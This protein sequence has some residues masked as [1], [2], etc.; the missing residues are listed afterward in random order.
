MSIWDFTCADTLCDL[1]VRKSLKRACSAAEEREFKKVDKYLNM[2]DNYHFVP[3]GI[4]T[5]G[6]FG[7]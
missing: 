5:S 2:S 3:V 7:P 4:E 1:Y 6:A